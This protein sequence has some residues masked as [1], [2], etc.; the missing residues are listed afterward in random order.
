MSWHADDADFVAYV[1][2]RWPFLV[3][4]LTLMGCPA[5]EAERLVRAGLARCY[6][7]WDE[8]LGS[9]GVVDPAFASRIGAGAAAQTIV[10]TAGLPPTDE[11]PA[12]PKFVADFKAAYG[13]EPAIGAVFGYEA[14][15]VVLAGIAAGHGDRAADLEQRA[16]RGLVDD[17]GVLPGHADRGAERLGQRLLGGEPRGQRGQRPRPLAGGEE[18]LAQARSA[19]EREPEA[20]DV[21]HVDAHPDDRHRWP[22]RP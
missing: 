12:L 5:P 6:V 7:A 14:M 13:H 15:Q 21:A 19:L 22:T 11:T 8:V 2:A 3:R 17:L 18:P 4:S 1:G 16:A 10:L 20:L 9:D